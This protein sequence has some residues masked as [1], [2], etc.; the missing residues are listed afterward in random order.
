MPFQSTTYMAGK[1]ARAIEPPGSE[2]RL[3]EE[4][5]ALPAASELAG[6]HDFA[7]YLAAA[8]WASMSI[9]LFQMCWMLRSWPTF[10]VLRRR[11][12]TAVWGASPPRHSWRD[13]T[14]A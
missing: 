10:G 9:R 13:G 4:I 3:S 7:V 11:C 2:R 1:R 8:F 12:W 5:A 14:L 6:N